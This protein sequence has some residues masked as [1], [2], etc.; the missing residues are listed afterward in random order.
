M[1]AA[2]YEKQGRARD[3]LVVGEMPD[4]IPAAGEVRIRIAASGINPGDIKKRQDAF[5]YGLAY[6]RVIPHSDGAGRVDLLGASVS[7]DWMGRSV[8]CY[9]AQSYRPFG[10]AAEYTVVP[11]DKIAPLPEKVSMEQGA[12]IGIPGITAHRCVHIAG[13]VKERTVLV[14]GAAGAVGVCAVA[15]ARH[16]GARVIGTVRS[17]SDEAAAKNAGA[18]EVIVSDKDLLSRVR[19]VVPDGVDHI[20]EVAFGS[21]ADA[22]VELLKPDGSIASYATDDPAAKIPFW[23]LVFKNIRLF[24]LGSDDF[25]K[26]AKIQAARDLNATL[27]AG[28][29]GFEIGERVPLA[30]IARAHE[31]V[32]HPVQRGR[33]VIVL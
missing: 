11:L 15:L 8:W 22:D 6:P 9:G 7:E 21:N 16:V 28:W 32:E 17:L 24:F 31:L 3:V 1:K 20:V 23:Q 29:P 19:A 27:E 33:V 12:C 26:E 13:A 10:T 5:G 4:P 30:E 14:Q 18:H 2:W 25:P